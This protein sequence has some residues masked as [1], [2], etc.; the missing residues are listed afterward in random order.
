MRKNI[1]MLVFIIVL[2]G[3]ALWSILPLQTKLLGPD[4]LTL[5]LDLRGGS[6]LLYEADLSKKDPS[7]TNAEAMSAVIEK[8]QRRVNEYGTTRCSI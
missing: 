5:G 3:L 4:G 8:I 7:I 6:Q 1:Y 2:F